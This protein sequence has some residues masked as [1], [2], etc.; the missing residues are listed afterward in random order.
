MKEQIFI[1]LAY[2][3]NSGIIEKV[4]QYKIFKGV[5]M[6]LTRI[7]IVFNKSNVLWI[8]TI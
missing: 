1:T 2:R 7:E 3:E 5:I 6:F 4:Q 8:H